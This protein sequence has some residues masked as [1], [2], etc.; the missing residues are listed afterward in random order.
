MRRDTTWLLRWAEAAS[1]QDLAR[2]M[3]VPTSWDPYFLPWMNRTDLLNW[4][5]K[6]YRHH[7]AQLTLTHIES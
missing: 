5:P 2:G 4:A 7:R 3:S 1:A 6:H